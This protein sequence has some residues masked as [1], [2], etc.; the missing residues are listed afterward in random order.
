MVLAEKLFTFENKLAM[1]LVALYQ[2][3]CSPAMMNYI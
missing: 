2:T 3:L 1:L